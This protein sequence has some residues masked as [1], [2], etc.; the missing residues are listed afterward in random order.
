MVDG[1]GVLKIVGGCGF[2]ETLASVVDS[3]YLDAVYEEV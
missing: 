2:Q 1:Y 3:S